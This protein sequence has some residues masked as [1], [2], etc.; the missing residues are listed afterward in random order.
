MPHGVVVLGEVRGRVW[1]AVRGGAHL[2]EAAESVGV[3][4]VAARLWLADCG[5]VIPP[6]SRAGRPGRGYRRLTVT[7]RETIGLML[8]ARHTLSE[9]VEPGWHGTEPSQALPAGT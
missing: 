4:Y 6:P 2:R 5:G 3:S 8:A 9:Q 1:A 7:D